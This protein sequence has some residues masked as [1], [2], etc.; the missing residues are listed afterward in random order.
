MDINE[1]L[2]IERIVRETHL[3]DRDRE[4]DALL[5]VIDSLRVVEPEPEFDFDAVSAAWERALP[6]LPKIMKWTPARKIKATQR[7]KEVMADRKR[8]GDAST[9]FAAWWSEIFKYASGS[10]FLTGDNRDGWTANIDFF[11]Q[12]SSLIKLREG[13]YHR[14]QQQQKPRNFFEQREKDT[15]DFLRTA[16]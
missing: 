14:N 5:T 1:A 7:W 11:L 10:A 12:P 16:E 8:R 4:V 13:A 15:D 2:R 6:T 3:G 9:E